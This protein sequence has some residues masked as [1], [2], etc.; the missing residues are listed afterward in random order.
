MP[1]RWKRRIFCRP[2]QPIH[3]LPS[4]LQIAT[5]HLADRLVA[6]RLIEG[7]SEVWSRDQRRFISV[8]QSKPARR[9]FLLILGSL[10]KLQVRM[11]T[12]V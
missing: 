4:F 1:V 11:K 5:G 3:D 6:L 9:R 12:A 8:P 10:W 7:A 2:D